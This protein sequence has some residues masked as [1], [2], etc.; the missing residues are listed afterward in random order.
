MT[1]MSFA[2]LHRST[3]A[4]A[5]VASICAAAVTTASAATS[6][7]GMI[8]VAH[9]TTLRQG[10]AVVGPLSMTQPMHIVVALKMQDRAGL[11]AFNAKA[12][13]D[14]ISGRAPQL[15]TPAQFLATHAPSQ[16][17][18]Q[19]VATYLASQGFKNIVIA[20]NRMLVSA[21]GNANTAGNAFQTSFVQVHTKDGRTAFANKQDA[22]IPLALQD[23]VLSVVGLQTVHQA[24]TFVHRAFAPVPGP[25]VLPPNHSH[26]PNDFYSIYGLSTAANS[27]GVVGAAARVTNVGIVTEGDLTQTKADL[28]TAYGAVVAGG[29][30]ILE[31]DIDGTSAD[32]SNSLEWELDSQAVA[33]IT[34]QKSLATRQING[35]NFYNIPSLSNS[36]LLD[37]YNTV[38]G[39]P[40]LITVI[41]VGECETDAKGDGSAAADDAVFAVAAAQGQTFAAGAGDLGADECGNGGVTPDWPASSPNVI[42]VGG[43]TLNA[44]STTWSSETVWNDGYSA[45]GGSPS[46]FETAPSWQSASVGPLEGSPATPLRGV[47]D[48]A[49]DGNPTVGASVYV[50]GT[51]VASQGGT[52]LSASLFAGIWASIITANSNHFGFAG[53]VLYALNAAH[54]NN[55]HDVTSGHNGIATTGETAAVGYDF[56]SGLGSMSF[57][58]QLLADSKTLGHKP[59]NA[60]FSYSL[61]GLTV[62]FT[63]T[64]TPA[65]APPSSIVAWSWTFGDGVGTST[66]RN[67]SYTY[68]ANGSYSVTEIVTDQVGAVSRKTETVKVL[69]TTPGNILLNPGFDNSTTSAAP[70]KFTSTSGKTNPNQAVGLAC[71]NA[72]EPAASAPCDMWLNGTG[73]SNT[74]TLS[75]AIQIGG[76]PVTAATLSFNMHID[77]A[78]TNGKANDT[79]K[80]QVV[81]S[82]GTATLATYSNLTAN[83]AP[84]VYASYNLDMSAY[85]GQVVTIK[86]VGVESSTKQTSFVLDDVNLIQN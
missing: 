74:S 10:D 43:T 21:D 42:A 23:S 1:N 84:G 63:D 75:Q 32:T 12:A 9:A 15:M 66:Q 7:A 41:P 58:T 3:L 37:A 33:G 53:P 46:T 26:N 76:T 86:F 45:T 20:S 14:Q 80:V 49:F 69:N 71:S 11:D 83:Q 51:T 47:P 70:W 39:T 67:P 73:G 81:S 40:V 82:S 24:H 78:E 56:A 36:N 18:A 52:G 48:V 29:I 25:G 30:P 35:I 64:S 28:E 27:G 31:T 8:S 19:K 65:S 72:S 38:L 77:T 2:S 59:A 17:Q 85:I 61:N 68:T 57:S 16:A 54:A 62:S 60:N 5:I 22:R 34:G 13:A 55:F 50:N 44:S 79:L 6:G 4:L